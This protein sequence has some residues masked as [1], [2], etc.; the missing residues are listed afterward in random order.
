MTLRELLPIIAFG[1]KPLS[2]YIES[3]NTPD[4]DECISYTIT[5][6]YYLEKKDFDTS[7]GCIAYAHGLIDAIR[8]IYKLI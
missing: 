5:D 1:P 4:Y 3:E 6:K 8:L 2:L 7:F